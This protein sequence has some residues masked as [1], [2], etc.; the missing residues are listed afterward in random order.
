[1]ISGGSG[2]IYHVAIKAFLHMNAGYLLPE[3]QE[4]FRGND[5]RK[6]LGG[7]LLF[8]GENADFIFP[9]RIPYGKENNETLNLGI[10][11]LN[12]AEVTE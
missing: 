1:M 7:I 9:F 6:T 3:G 11:H 2:N 5:R 12:L 8:T 4:P 10:L